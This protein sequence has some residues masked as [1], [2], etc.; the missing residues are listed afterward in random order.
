VS[1][2][3]GIRQEI[4]SSILAHFLDDPHMRGVLS[5]FPLFL[6]LREDLGLAGALERARRAVVAAA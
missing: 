3:P 5:T 2:K 1:L 4:E 6:V